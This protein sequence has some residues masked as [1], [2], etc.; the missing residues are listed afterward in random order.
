[1]IEARLHSK[2]GNS[3]GGVWNRKSELI[4]LVEGGNDSSIRY[5]L[6]NPVT[7]PKIDNMIRRAIAWD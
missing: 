2:T 3:G 6:I 7:Q 1:M 5:T 4:G